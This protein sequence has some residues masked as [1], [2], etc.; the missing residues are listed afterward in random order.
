[1]VTQVLC[2]GCTEEKETDSAWRHLR[3]EAEVGSFQSNREGVFLL[4]RGEG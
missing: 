4:L 2:F 3:R 1:M